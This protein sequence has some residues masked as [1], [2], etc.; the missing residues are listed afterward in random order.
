MRWLAWGCAL[1]VCASAAG[2][3]TVDQEPTA[4]L[5]SKFSTA[6]DGSSDTV[7]NRAFVPSAEKR[8][9]EVRLV[10]RDSGL[11]VQTLLYSKLLKRVVARIGEK[12]R[13][14]W[15]SGSDG[16]RDS[17]TYVDT[18]VQAQ[19]EIAET[20]REGA[21]ED[22]RR[23]AMLIEFVC[24]PTAALVAVYEPQV[25]QAGEELTIT[26][27][28]LLAILEPSRQYVFENMKLI[29]ADSLGLPEAEIYELFDGLG[30]PAHN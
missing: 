27:K 1:C 22:D 8:H 17:L 6:L 29:V 7:L 10:R 20:S 21:K 13:Q 4:A 19:Q 28:R 3:T 24:Q 11:T 5:A 26:D 18:I 16:H 30:S 23:Q 25:Q 14:Q 15:P 12:E 2:G 9:G